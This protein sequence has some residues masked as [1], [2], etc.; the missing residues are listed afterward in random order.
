MEKIMIKRTFVLILVAL[1][2]FNFGGLVYANSCDDKKDEC[3]E[4]CNETWEG[5]SGLIELGRATCKGGCQVGK[6]ICNLT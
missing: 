5:D 2:S 6:L 4:E 1:F 3:Y